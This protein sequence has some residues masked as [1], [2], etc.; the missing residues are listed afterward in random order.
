MSVFC[1]NFRVY[2]HPDWHQDLI[3]WSLGHVLPLLLEF[4]QNPEMTFVSGGRQ[5]YTMSKK[6]ATWYIVH[7]FAKY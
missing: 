1:K 7:I 2:R 6:H 4:H 5:I 3:S